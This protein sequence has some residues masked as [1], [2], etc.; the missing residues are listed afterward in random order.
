MKKILFIISSLKRCGPVN[1]LFDIIKY[2]DGSKYTTHILTLRSEEDDSRWNEF[3]DLGSTVTKLDIRGGF[4][5]ILS[6]LRLRAAVDRIQ[7]DVLHCIG[8]R[9]DFLASLC[10]NKHKKLSSQLNFPFEDYVM[11]YGR[12]V[13]G[14]MAQ[15]TAWALKRHDVAVACA[16]D[17]AIRM[18]GHGV[19]CRVVYNAIDIELFTP[20]NPL[21]RQNQ[22]A[23]L[24]IP[25]DIKYVFI[26]VGVLTDR[27][28]PLIALR[29]FLRFKEIHPDAIL[30]ILG[31][32]PELKSCCELIQGVDGVVFA[33][34]VS[35]TLPYL[36][37]S[38]AY[39][40]TS[41]AEGMPLSVVEG[42]AMRLPVVLSDI[43]P[44]QEILA[45]DPQAGVLAR[46]GS[47]DETFQAMIELVGSDLIIR[48]AHAR[49]IVEHELNSKVM[50]MKYQG[51]YAE[52]MT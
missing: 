44:H 33:G 47:V 20:P 39:I 41:K 2:V 42:M 48:G 35:A 5:W 7:P 23:K 43:K 6:V 51:I 3:V 14:G 32:G 34:R 52:L 21:E 24:G 29:A 50:S 15:L 17:V 37:A 49:N 25:S 12:V 18:A 40:A 28:Q 27:K 16:N 45:I 13:G 9:A 19:P 10:L 30:L 38:D 1:I 11:T 26:F 46:T 31:D 36:I 22:R 4:L 8:F